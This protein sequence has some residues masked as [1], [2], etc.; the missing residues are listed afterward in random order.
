MKLYHA[1]SAAQAILGD[2]F[3]DWSGSYGLADTVD[4]VILRIS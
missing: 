2:G 3:R 1:T 4:H